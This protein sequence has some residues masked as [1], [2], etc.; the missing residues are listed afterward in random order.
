MGRRRQ[1]GCLSWAPLIALIATALTIGAIVTSPLVIDVV[2]PT[3]AAVDQLAAL[4]GQ[5]QDPGKVRFGVQLDW[6]NDSPQAYTDRVGRQP[7]LYGEFVEFPLRPQV[8]TWLDTK[9]DQVR[10]ADAVFM[11]T[12][13]PLGGLGSISDDSLR[14]LTAT[15]RA[16]NDTGV[17]VLVRFAH[18]MNGS[19]YPW[20]QQPA[21]YIAAFRRVSTAVRA[22]PASRIVW[23]PN[24]AGGYPFPLGDHGATPEQPDYGLLDTNGDGKLT[25]A[26]DPYEPYYP[27]DEY[28]DWVGLSLYHFGYQYPWGANIV[29]EPGKFTGKITGEYRDPGTSVAAPNFYQRYAERP[30]KL[31]AISETSALFNTSRS[32]DGASDLDIKVNWWRQVT[33]DDIPTRLPRLRLINWFEQEK[34]E[35]DLAGVV[36]SWSIIR[37]PQIRGEFIATIPNW[38]EFPHTG[39]RGL[40]DHMIE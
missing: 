33:A 3:R 38:L 13:E 6:Q 5:R 23:S 32:G 28:V 1:P 37:D 40:L 31:M 4:E 34:K 19:W 24:E 14:L 29:P 22:A 7:S 27:G 35:Q 30:G 2:D 10:G 16:W 36:T 26:D 8:A 20:G 21:A 25:A 39:P 11:L 9:A 17:A 12:L 15:L 18:E